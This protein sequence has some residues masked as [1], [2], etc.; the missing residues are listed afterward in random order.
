[1]LNNEEILKSYR[2]VLDADNRFF[3]RDKLRSP[4]AEF[5]SIFFS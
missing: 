4:F 5:L 3:V 2:L 1:M